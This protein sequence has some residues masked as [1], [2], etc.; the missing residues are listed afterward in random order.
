M[1]YDSVV[2]LLLWFSNCFFL[3]YRLTREECYTSMSLDLTLIF[4]IFEVH[5]LYSCFVI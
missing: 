5:I 2:T 4:D 1:A 3:S